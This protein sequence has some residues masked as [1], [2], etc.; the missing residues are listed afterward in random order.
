MRKASST[1][2]A[3]GVTTVNINSSARQLRVEKF[4]PISPLLVQPC[5]MS[6]R[7]SPFSV[8][9]GHYLVGGRAW[10]DQAPKPTFPV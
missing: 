4:A 1:I 5:T 10:F 2:Q 9:I 8:P 7:E 6:I 3:V